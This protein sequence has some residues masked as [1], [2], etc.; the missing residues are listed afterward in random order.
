MTQ[1]VGYLDAG[2]A[3]TPGDLLCPWNTSVS[4][5]FNANGLYLYQYA[6][7][8]KTSA[9]LWRQSIP[10]ASR[11]VL[12]PDGDFQVLGAGGQLLW[13][14][15]T[16]AAGSR[17]ECAADGALTLVATSG[18][19]SWHPAGV[20]VADSTGYLRTLWPGQ[21][22]NCTDVF[23]SANGRYRL[24]MQPDGNL[25]LYGY[26]G[27]TQ[28]ALWSSG[29]FQQGGVCAVMQADGNFVLY[30]AGG[31]S[32]GHALWSSHTSG[33][34]Q[35]GTALTL[36]DDGKLALSRDGTEVWS[37]G[38]GQ[39]NNT[40]YS[41]FLDA[42]QLLNIGDSLYADN[43]GYT[44]TLQSDG[45]L[46]LYRFVSAPG[47]SGETWQRLWAAG[48]VGRGASQAVM[49]DDGNFVVYDGANRPLRGAG[50]NNS[51]SGNYLF[52]EDT[53]NLSVVNDGKTCW[54][55]ATT[56]APQRIVGALLP[57]CSLQVGDTLVSPNGLYRLT[58]TATGDVVWSVI[59]GDRQLWHSNTAGQ[60]GHV[61][62]MQTDGNLV[63]YSLG[64]QP[65]GHAL[66]AS[67]TSK[68]GCGALQAQDD[69]NL[70]LYDDCGDGKARWSSDTV[71]SS[72]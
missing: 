32:S 27:N 17:L 49:Q 72:G 23:W 56:Q 55:S 21:Q 54:T 8:G 71:Q 33:G 70:V 57:A 36:Y 58:L 4:L 42:G 59:E 29:T 43:L 50:S 5:C 9:V 31:E 68:Y 28:Q 61:L 46:A 66:W 41:P 26:Q 69:G 22:L 10:N 65:R 47:A 62:V 60:G 7:G 64:G 12:Q 39:G 16:S 13:N 25:V 14:T 2:Q 44:L 67:H 51:A 15:K 35:N 11:A 20:T 1:Y 52:L 30:T 48:T 53:G 37:S 6:P 3:M 38:T 63:L 40:S 18:A 34:D 45:E 24:V 19:V